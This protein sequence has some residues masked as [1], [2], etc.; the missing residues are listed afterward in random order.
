MIA[1]VL[2]FVLGLVFLLAACLCAFVAV[3]GVHALIL[4]R[5]EVWG[6]AFCALMFGF[7]AVRLMGAV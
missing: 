3:V 1:A 5:Y 2:A 6:T 7:I 4:T